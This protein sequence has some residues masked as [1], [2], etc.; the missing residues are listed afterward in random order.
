M[1][2]FTRFHEITVTRRTE[3]LQ[4]SYPERHFFPHQIYFLPKAGPDGIKTATSAGLDV[5]PDTLWE[6]LVYALPPVLD[7]FPDALYFNMDVVWHQQ[8]LFKR[9]LVATANVVIQN[10]ALYSTNHLSDLVQR[11]SRQR[12]HKTRIEN[13]FK[14]WHHILLNAILYFALKQN[15]EMVY[16]PCAER[17][18]ALADSR[19]RD[20]IKTELFERVYD[21]A[22]NAHYEATS[23][24]GWWMLD[25]AQNHDRVIV[26]E[27][28]EEIGGAPRKTICVC[29][30]IERGLGHQTTDRKLAK[31]A[32]RN[33]PRALHEMLT[34]EKQANIHATYNVV[35]ILMDAT[36]AEIERDGHCIAFHSYNHNLPSEPPSSERSRIQK[37]LARFQPPPPPPLRDQLA[38]CRGIDYRL[39]G[40][41]APQS[42]IN[43]DLGTENLLYHN[44]EWLASSAYSFGFDTPQLQNRIVKI[45]ILFDDYSLYTREYKYA[46]WEENALT[47]IAAHDFVALSLH[48]CY[49][50]FW[51]PHY[52]RFLEKIR[53]LGEFQTLDQV[54]AN[55]FLE[56]AV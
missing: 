39:K 43:A 56:N 47:K 50:P 49:A 17:V 3:F 2:L 11:I 20:T 22:V 7:E 32:D 8:H 16:V 19:R 10:N 42:L 46:Q 45:P 28:K 36:R 51:L 33:A 41:R 31:E 55:V 35:G 12:E 9:G 34:L 23:E 29:H 27:S 52:K 44:F 24:N 38:H 53:A 15:L 21:Q 4:H 6:I 40:Y 25:V 54:A 13:R 5:T 30:D 14:G 1:N 48:D 37:F 26:P 18:L